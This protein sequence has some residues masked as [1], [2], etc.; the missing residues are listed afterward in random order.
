MALRAGARL[1]G[2]GVGLLVAGG[3]LGPAYDHSHGLV[4]V[5]VVAIDVVALLAPVLALPRRRPA[6]G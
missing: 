3:V 2:P 1:A 4:I 6:S 5:L